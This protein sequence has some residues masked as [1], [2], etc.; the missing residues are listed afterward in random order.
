MKHSSVIQV[1]TVLQLFVAPV[2]LEAQ[3][4]KFTIENCVNHFEMDNAT[5]TKSG[6]RYWGT[7]R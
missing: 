2:A 1:L 5:K 7:D 6:Y 3:A 4:K